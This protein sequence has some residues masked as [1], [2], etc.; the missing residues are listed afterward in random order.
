MAFGRERGGLVGRNGVGKTSLLRLNLGDLVPTHGTVSVTGRVA[1]LR[2][3]PLL[4]GGAQ[5]A[6]V[7]GARD[8]M[9][10]LARLERGEGADDDLEAAD[11]LLPQRIEEAL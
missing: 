5:I 10:R 7:I 11:W 4:A 8:G 1:H 9:D 6:D 3:V 2:Q